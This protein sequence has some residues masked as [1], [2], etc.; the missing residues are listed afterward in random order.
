MA[1]VDRLAAA[2]QNFDLAIEQ[3]RVLGLAAGFA[4]SSGSRCQVLIR[5]GRLVEAET[6]ALSLL[7]T[8]KPH[9]IARAML[10]SSVIHTMT[11][12]ATVAAAEGFLSENGL[13]GDL[14]EMATGS[15][16]L[17]ARGRLRLASGA[18]G[19]ALDDFEQLR[20]PATTTPT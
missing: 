7:A 13:D 17:F 2:E 12:R 10:R 14:S 5:E 3:A 11:E 4:A 19:L 18:S 8:L 6:E 9:A 16:L 15:M 20:L 1:A